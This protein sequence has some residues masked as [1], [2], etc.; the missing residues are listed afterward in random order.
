MPIPEPSGSDGNVKKTIN[1]GA[2]IGG[3]IGVV[4]GALT[5]FVF[6][7]WTYRKK[8]ALLQKIMIQGDIVNSTSNPLVYH[9]VRALNG[10]VSP[11]LKAITGPDESFSSFEQGMSPF[12]MP[13]L[14]IESEGS[15]P[16][17]ANL[18]KASRRHRRYGVQILPSTERHDDRDQAE[19]TPADHHPAESPLEHNEETTN[20]TDLITYRHH[21]SGWRDPIELRSVRNEIV[22]GREVIELPP[23]YSEV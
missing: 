4:L 17:Q 15:S 20:Q 21:D 8:Q 12:I 18:D 16:L 13:D 11:Y 2:V 23:D 7:L 22:D 6:L 19:V 5:L 3:T 10:S 14:A 1:L 9:R